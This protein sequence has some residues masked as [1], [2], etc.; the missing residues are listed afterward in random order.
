MYCVFSFIADEKSRVF[1]PIVSR[2]REACDAKARCSASSAGRVDRDELRVTSTSS[3]ATDTWPH[4]SR[5]RADTRVAS[6]LVIVASIMAGTGVAARH[7]ILIK[8]AEALETAHAVTMVVLWAAR[9][10][11]WRT[12]PQFFMW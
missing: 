11:M 12:G 10:V 6:S 1:Q 3:A 8:D 2:R 7:G 5:A 4:R 9:L